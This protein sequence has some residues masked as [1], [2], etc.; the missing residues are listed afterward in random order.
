MSTRKKVILWI[1]IAGLC[2]FAVTSARAQSTPFLSNREIQML[3]N[4]ISGDRAFEHIR[5]LS[6][7]HRDSG[8][9]GF[10]KAAEYV[11][12]TAKEVGL[13]DVQFIEQPLD[14]P[15][16]NARSAELWMVEPVEVK[17]ADIG[18]HALYLADGS[19]DADVTAELVWIGDAS[20]EALEGKDVAGKIVLT[21]ASP[22]AA[23]R[24]AVWGKGAV[25]V[26]SYVLSER[27]SLMDFPDQIAWTRI[28]V[29]P[30][31]GKPATFAFTLPPRKGEILRKILQSKGLQDYF[32]TGE[33]APG[34]RVVLH[35]RV[36]TDISEKPGR[37]GFIEGWI[38]GTKYP[39]Q[40]IM[41]TA[42]LQ[43]E[44]GSANDDGSGSGNILELARVFNKLIAEGK[45]KPPLRDLRFWW[46]DEIYSE[47]RYFQD[48]PDEP[49]KMLVDLHQDMTG[50]LQSMGNRVQ[51]LIFAPYSRTSFLDALF[52]S[53]GTY[54]IQTNNAFLPAGRQ[55]GLPHPFS[56]PI[57]ST[58]GSRDN[59]A[60]R[61]VPYFD[62]SD[63]RCFLEGAVG[64]PAVALI[65]W[66]DDYI[67]SSDDDLDNVDP[68]QL[69]R[70]NF[71]IAAMAYYLAFAEADD[72]PLLAGATFAQG[73]RRLARDLEVGMQRLREDAAQGWK[74]A[75]MLA[76]QGVK[77]ELRALES[78]RVFA[79]KDKNANRLIDRLKDRMKG[80]RSSMLAD[81]RRYYQ[82]VHGKRPPGIRLS[83]AEKAAARK[84][85]YNVPLPE[86]FAKRR[87]VRFRGKLHPLMRDEVY[88][89]V[90]G[91]RS[92]LD[93]Y[94]AVRA[95]ALAAGE[96]YYGK[97]RFEDVVGLLDAAV[98]AGCLALK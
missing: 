33:R 35:A 9:D 87:E 67:H 48:H 40:Q 6:H 11:E 78:V 79:G 97:V 4:E 56:R 89:Y 16:Y 86:Y 96:W 95:E 54:L 43:E 71:L 45:M 10:F 46:T 21:T 94:H 32:A 12:K 3:V 17:L 80:R 69:R 98:Q 29:Q 28:P 84:V 44:Q 27:K 53:I 50:A 52:E 42:H 55:G 7:W 91:K 49:K 59:Y 25:G 30:P 74:D 92:Y 5:W 61:F 76:D 37:T 19:H 68:T 47:Y 58:R 85:P 65:N 83:E 63:H 51:Q 22:A 36:D 34:G 88:N 26:V 81:L 41:I 39:N 15:S 70:N 2:S 8:M 77:R 38:H 24:T 13:Q 64:V 23:V 66:P 57:Y 31:E 1:G 73:T 72:V 20:K 90:D 14:G 62:S 60:A 93:I 18:D 75:M 82:Q